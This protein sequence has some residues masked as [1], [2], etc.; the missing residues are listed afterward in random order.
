MINAA[1]TRGYDLSAHRAKQLEAMDCEWATHVIAV[2][3]AT[4]EEVKSGFPHVDWGKISLLDK[5][6]L[7]IKDPYG[8]SPEDFATCLGQ[9]LECTQQWVADAINRS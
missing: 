7:D 2:D 6:G 3:T 8:G 4:I 5:G 9:I 1:K